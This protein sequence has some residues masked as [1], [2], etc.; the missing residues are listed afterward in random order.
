M[1]ERIRFVARGQSSDLLH[2]GTN[3]QE[4]IRALIDRVKHM[5]G[6][7]PCQENSEILRHLRLALSAFETRAI[8]R[9]VEKSKLLPES[10]MTEE[11]DGH[12]VFLPDLDENEKDK[13]G[14]S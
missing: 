13:F 12:W 1:L 9:K 6:I 8:R 14:T 3:C 11:C 10:I 4:V 7:L 2:G 5:D